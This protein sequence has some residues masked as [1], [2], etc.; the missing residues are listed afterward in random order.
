MFRMMEKMCM[1]PGENRWRATYVADVVRGHLV[2]DDMHQMADALQHIVDSGELVIGQCKD[3]FSKRAKGGWADCQLNI[4]LLDDSNQHK[5][6]IQIVHKKLLAVNKGM[7]EHDTYAY[8]RSAWEMLKLHDAM[9]REKQLKSSHHMIKH[10]ELQYDPDED[11][12]G[13][14]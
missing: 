3:R 13:E 10:T 5:C 4:Y 14:A 9:L 1:R 8:F 12:L 7:D 2:Y 11:E 6:E